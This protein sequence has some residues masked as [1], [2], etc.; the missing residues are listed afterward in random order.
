MQFGANCPTNQI[1][2][3]SFKIFIFV[4]SI[5]QAVFPKRMIVQFWDT[6]ENPRS[7]ERLQ[8]GIL[9]KECAFITPDSHFLI[10]SA[11]IQIPEN[12]SIFD[13]IIRVTSLQQ[14]IVL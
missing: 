12:R 14:M 3:V 7:L 5:F 8:F 13:G 10:V 11:S 9:S 6:R 1:F 4:L 2:N